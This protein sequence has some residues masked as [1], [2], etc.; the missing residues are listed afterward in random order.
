MVLVVFMFIKT[1][2]GFRMIKLV[3]VLSEFIR[4][5]LPSIYFQ[6]HLPP[7]PENQLKTYQL[8]PC[9]HLCYYQLSL[10]K[11][12]RKRKKITRGGCRGNPLRG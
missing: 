1:L 10:K 7:V 11:R 2:L 9:V 12:K 8:L 5:V 4:L 6:A 3:L